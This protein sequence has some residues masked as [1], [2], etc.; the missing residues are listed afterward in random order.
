M[1]TSFLLRHC[2]P[3][4]L[5]AIANTAAIMT[6]R[7]IGHRLWLLSRQSCAQLHLPRML[8][9]VRGPVPA[10]T[11]VDGRQVLSRQPVH[12]PELSLYGCMAPFPF[13]LSRGCPANRCAQLLT[14][15]FAPTWPYH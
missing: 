13:W 11:R 2:A 9:V 7:F 3:A 6:G 15:R 5:I 10:T 12:L 14:F 4:G 1:L 8:P